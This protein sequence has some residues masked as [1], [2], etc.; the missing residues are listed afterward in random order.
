LLSNPD[1]GFGEPSVTE[2]RRW[3]SRNDRDVNKR[4]TGSPS[5][6]AIIQFDST[7]HSDCEF[8]MNLLLHALINLSWINPWVMMKIPRRLIQKHV[9]KFAVYIEMVESTSLA[10]NVWH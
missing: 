2:R 1:K 5:G 6:Q 4:R 3:I 9:R 7:R 8:S 10:N